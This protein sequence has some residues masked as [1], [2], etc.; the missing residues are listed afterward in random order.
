MSPA[1]TLPGLGRCD[2]LAMKLDTVTRFLREYVRKSEVGVISASDVYCRL[3]E[4]DF[5]VFDCNLE[6]MWR[7]G[8]VPGAVYVGYDTLPADKLPGR[9]DATLVFYCGSSL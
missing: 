9:R 7:R 5:H 2:E 4:P 3:G 1:V 8:Q 6:V